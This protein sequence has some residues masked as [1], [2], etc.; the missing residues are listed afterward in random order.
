MNFINRSFFVSLQGG[1]ILQIQLTGSKGGF[2]CM[3]VCFF[4]SILPANPGGIGFRARKLQIM[5]GTAVKRIRMWFGLYIS[6]TTV[7]ISVNLV[8]NGW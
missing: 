5:C 1:G 3:F 4:F 6:T 2:F 8:R 7:F